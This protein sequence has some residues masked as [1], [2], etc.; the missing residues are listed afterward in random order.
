MTSYPGN[1][2]TEAQSDLSASYAAH[3]LAAAG[4]TA[5]IAG[6]E[7]SVEVWGQLRGELERVVLERD[8]LQLSLANLE[9]VLGLFETEKDVQKSL[10]DEHYSSKINVLLAKIAMEQTALKEAT[11]RV[12]LQEIELKE[13]NRLRADL[14][15]ANGICGSLRRY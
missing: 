2:V 1:Q 9:N 12:H 14:N 13:A 6:L 8:R 11:E 10:L 15:V 3:A 4:A 5:R 7:Q